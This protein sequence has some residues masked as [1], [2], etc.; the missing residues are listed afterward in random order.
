MVELPVA[1]SRTELAANPSS[2]RSAMKRL[3][4]RQKCFGETFCPTSF[5]SRLITYRDMPLSA[6]SSRLH[7]AG[8]SHARAGATFRRGVD[9][10]D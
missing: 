4:I 6:L 3:R 8:N 1:T 9:S 7:Q 10:R 5:L 2:N